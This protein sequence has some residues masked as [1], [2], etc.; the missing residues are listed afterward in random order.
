MENS[1]SSCSTVV[2]LVHHIY[3]R[4]RFANR[5][6]KE[7]TTATQRTTHR[8][9]D[10]FSMFRCTIYVAM[11]KII[12]ILLYFIT[13]RLL[14]LLPFQLVRSVPRTYLCNVQCVFESMPIKRRTDIDSS[15]RSSSNN[16][17]Y[18]KRQN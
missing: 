12:L 8:Q 3:S 1:R 10:S 2:K 16:R 18:R 6:M 5:K 14:F 17:K 9:S 15:S 13:F 11:P 4:L 7:K